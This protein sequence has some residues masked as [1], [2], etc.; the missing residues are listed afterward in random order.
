MLKKIADSLLQL[1]NN[2]VQ[3]I[4]A[5][6]NLFLMKELSLQVENSQ[7]NLSAQFFSLAQ[8]ENGVNRVEFSTQC[9]DFIITTRI[10]F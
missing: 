4:L 3:I 7:G 5:T 6:H 10:A 2:G 9:A 8:E 1:V